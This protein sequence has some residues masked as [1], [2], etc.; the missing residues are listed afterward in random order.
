MIYSVIV[1][2]FIFRIDI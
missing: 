1:G 2:D